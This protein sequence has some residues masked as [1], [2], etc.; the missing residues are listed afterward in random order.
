MQASREES[1]S[2]KNDWHLC[3]LLIE[4]SIEIRTNLE[5]GS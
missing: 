2:C 5:M 3:Q 1:E 4:L